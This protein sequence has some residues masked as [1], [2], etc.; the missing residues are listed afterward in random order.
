MVF[1]REVGT[2]KYAYICI[3]VKWK[4]SQ[5]KHS[6]LRKYFV[7]LCGKTIRELIGG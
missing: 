4:H 7:C 6:Y 5:A 2:E 3:L 1:R